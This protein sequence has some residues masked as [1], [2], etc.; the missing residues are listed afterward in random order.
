MLSDS[1]VGVRNARKGC[2][3][4]RVTTIDSVRSCDM[5]KIYCEC[6]NIVSIDRSMVRMKKSLKKN[7]E[8]SICRN[9]RIS[10]DIE[11]LNG[12]YEGTLDADLTA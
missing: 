3:M 12:L 8:C 7:V 6:G 4:T 11:Y 2:Q 1:A 5:S 9:H 10:F